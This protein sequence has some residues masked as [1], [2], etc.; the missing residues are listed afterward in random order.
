VKAVKAVTATRAAMTGAGL[1]MAG[2]VALV[3]LCLGTGCSTAAYYGQAVRG[4]LDLM[5]RARPLADLLV[6]PATPEPRRDR[7]RLAQ[8][9]RE[10]AVT[11]LKLPDN[12]SYRRF[13]E[14][15]RDAAVWNVVA[16]PE[17]SLTLKTWCFAVMGCVSY[18]GYF[19]RGGADA[20]AAQLRAEGW[21]VSVYPVPAYSTLGWSNWIGGDPLL[22]TFIGWPEG[23]LA[24]LIFHELSHQ[25][26]YVPDDT[27]FN[28]SFAV[29]VE[30]IG[31]QRWL[32]AHGGEGT[33]TEL[34]RRDLRREDFRTFAMRCRAWPPM[35]PSPP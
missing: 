3:S 13:A 17:L 32:Q 7:L 2:V 33:R 34:A 28:E 23:E 8:R 25:I 31:G 16:A 9:M 18:R 1:A 12:P 21:E 24:R 6:D 11:E 30:R 20:Q 4:H 29:A 27:T 10:F 15:G 5:W 26:V 19:D 14:L 22:S 35:R